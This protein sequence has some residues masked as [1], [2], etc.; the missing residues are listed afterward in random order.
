MASNRIEKYV[1]WEQTPEGKASKV[2]DDMRTL[3][4]AEKIRNDKTRLSAV[5]CAAKDIMQAVAESPSAPS[6]AKKV[7]AKS[8]PS[9][10]E[11]VK[12]RESK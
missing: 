11:F 1:P 4:E 9:M 6:A 8:K 5:Q 7:A 2:R 3:Q 12:Q 10:N